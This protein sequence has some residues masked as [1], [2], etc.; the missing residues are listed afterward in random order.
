MSSRED[1]FL[2]KEKQHFKILYID[3]DKKSKNNYL[4]YLKNI[5]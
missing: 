2:S 4:L 1:N 3:N 5:I